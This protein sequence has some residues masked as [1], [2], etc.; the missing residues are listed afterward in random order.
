MFPLDP[1]CNWSCR[2]FPLFV[3]VVRCLMLRSL[4]PLQ[5]CATGCNFI[6]AAQRIRQWPFG[7][8]SAFCELERGPHKES[9]SIP[10]WIFQWT[11][12]LTPIGTSVLFTSP[13]F[14]S[15]FSVFSQRF[16]ILSNLSAPVCSRSVCLWRTPLAYLVCVCKSI[17]LPHYRTVPE[18]FSPL[19]PVTL[20]VVRCPRVI[21]RLSPS[22]LRCDERSSKYR[23]RH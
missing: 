14:P 1:C 21:L 20:C 16:G 5:C 11:E 22:D 13:S 19:L 8:L 12:P 3:E 10:Y 15:K 17:H 23:R 6:A 4:L 9:G 7:K 2:K 18:T